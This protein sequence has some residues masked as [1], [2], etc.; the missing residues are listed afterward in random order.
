M[1]AARATFGVMRRAAIV[2]LFVVGCSEPEPPRTAAGTEVLT[3][4]S[5]RHYG[6]GGFAEGEPVGADTEH[7]D[8]LTYTPRPL[9]GLMDPDLPDARFDVAYTVGSRTMRRDDGTTF[10]AFVPVAVHVE[11]AEASDWVVTAHCDDTIAS[12]LPPSTPDGGFEYQDG[13]RFWQA[14]WLDLAYGEL[15]RYGVSLDVQGDGRIEGHA[16][17][18]AVSLA[19]VR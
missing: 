3:W 9:E 12:P 11:T 6:A 18:G 2:L 16:A 8:V 19:R 13:T 5:S 10:S 1:T 15:L 14:C 7:A 17:S 4:T